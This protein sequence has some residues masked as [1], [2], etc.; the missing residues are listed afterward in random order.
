MPDE[1]RLTAVPVSASGG[2][3]AFRLG[4]AGENLRRPGRSW[5]LTKIAAGTVARLWGLDMRT[6]AATVRRFGA[7]PMKAQRQSATWLAW[8]VALRVGPSA[9]E[10]ARMAAVGGSPV[11]VSIWNR[12]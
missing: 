2:L 8:R 11:V 10:Q 7:P 9:A 6:S 4:V 5:H 3:D 1:T 12:C